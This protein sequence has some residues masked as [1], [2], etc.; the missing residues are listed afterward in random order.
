MGVT[1]FVTDD[2]QRAEAWRSPGRRQHLKA[3]YAGS[4]AGSPSPCTATCH[5]PGVERTHAWNRLHPSDAPPVFVV[6]IGVRHR[7]S[8]RPS[9]PL[10]QPRLPAT[11]LRAPPR[12]R[13]STHGA[14]PSGSSRRRLVVRHRLRARRLDR[15]LRPNARHAHQRATRRTPARNTVRRP[16]EDGRGPV[17][18]TDAPSRV[19]DM[20]GRRRL[21]SV[22]LRHQCIERTVQAAIAA[23]RHRRTAHR[24]RQRSQLDSGE[25][26]VTAASG[27]AFV[28]IGTDGTN[29]LSR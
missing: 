21:E 12:I 16:G 22:A 13:T 28:K 3:L 11:C 25:L 8:S 6:C 23:R 24:T 10:L 14:T 18:H 26:T 2:S 4:T 15:P 17:L 19:S 27:A 29:T 5:T 20:H 1:G 7:L 9:S